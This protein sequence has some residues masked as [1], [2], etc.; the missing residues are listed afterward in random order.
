MVDSILQDLRFAVRSLRK[1]PLFLLIPVISLAIG[2]GANTTIFSIVNRFLLRSAEGVPNAS[3]VVEL[4]RG[5][6]GA[7]FDSFS[8]PDFLDLRQQAEPLEALAGMEARILTLSRGDAGERALGMLVSANFFDVLGVKAASGRTFSPEEDEGVDEHPVVV[9]SHQFWKNR[10]G[11]DPDIL[12]STVYVSRKPYTVVGV[13]PEEFRGHMAVANPDAYVPMMQHPSLNEGRSQFERRGSSW[14]QVL[15]LLKERATVREADAAVL[16]VMERLQEEYPETNAHRTAAV[17]PYGAL[18][19]AIR[20]PAGMFLAVLAAFVGLILLITCANVAGMFLARALSRRKEIAIRLSLGSDRGRLIRHLLAESLLVFFLGGIGGMVL[21]GWSLSW[22]TSL[23]L[24]APIPL[25]L[26]LDPDMR[27]FL[28]SG[29]VTLLT[30][31]LFG[32]LPAR[33]A[34]KLD[35]LGSLKDEGGRSGSSESRLR[36]GFVAAQVAASLVLLVAA[37]LLLRTLQHA[38]SI[39]TGFQAEG[40]YVTFVDLT[41]EGYEAEDGAVFQEEILHHFSSLP[42]VESVAL[43][44]DLPLDLSSRRTIVEPEG[45]EGGSEEGPFGSG[46]N[47]VSPAYFET[48]RIPILEGRGLDERDRRGNEP[49]AVV[50]RAFL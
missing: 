14:F 21:A 46:F 25:A 15:G 1:R 42:W 7:G 26:R 9:L 11:G 34:L 3:R 47:S 2:I 22:L 29:L 50:S 16:T 18:P 39:E 35:L 38:G 13:L 19:S 4:G 36:K 48:L 5:R 30:G 33:Q 45:W 17:R 24:P 10:W 20:G 32:L 49:V 8:Y 6:D 43:S 37:G 28:F 12:G 41:A 27:V 31:L 44:V 40:A 23:D